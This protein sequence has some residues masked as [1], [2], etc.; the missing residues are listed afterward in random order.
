MCRIEHLRAAGKAVPRLRRGAPPTPPRAARCYAALAA[1]SEPPRDKLGAA[2]RPL[3]SA[4]PGGG[5]TG[6]YSLRM[7]GEPLAGRAVRTAQPSR[8]RRARPPGHTCP[9]EATLPSAMRSPAIKGHQ[10][11]PGACRP[12]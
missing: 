11:A 2:P 10:A 5:S 6:R 7:E 12:P 9:S 4:R 1:L 8:A 3:R